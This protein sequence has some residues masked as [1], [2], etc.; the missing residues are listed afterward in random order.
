MKQL[1][2]TAAVAFLASF[3]SAQNFP[4]GKP[5]ST[6]YELTKYSKDTSA[7][8]VVLREFG[9]AYISNSD[10]NVVF[11]YH[12]RI[13]IFNS[14]G[15]K[16]GTIEIPLR[17]NDANT[18]ETIRDIKGVTFYPDEN[19]LLRSANLESSQIFKESKAGKYHDLVKFAMP[20][21]KDG[22]IIE[23]SYVIE[24]PFRHNFRNWDFQSEIPKIYTEYFAK[25][26]A[27]YNYN[28]ALRGAE[29]L[30]KNTAVLEKE[31]FNPGGG[32]KADCSVM[33]W[34]M[35][36]VPAFYEE[37]YMT[38]ASNFRSAM[39]FELS[40]YTDYYGGKHAVT[41][42]WKDVD[43]DL[44]KEDA[45][46]IQLKKKDFFE[47]KVAP[48]TAGLSSELEKAKAIYNFI[49]GWYKWDNYSGKYSHTGLKKAFENRTGNAGDINLSMVAA[50]NAGGL[51]AEPV[52]LSTRSN[53]IVNNLFPVL[54][55]FD[56]VICKVNIGENFYLLDGTDPLLPFGLLP[57]R[58]INDK[59]RVMSF[60]KPSYWI[61]LKASQKETRTITLDLEMDE[62]GKMKGR[63]NVF[64]A[65]YAAYGK[66]KEIKSFN[67]VDEFVESLDEKLPKIKILK[68]EVRNLDSLENILGESY[69]IEI[70]ATEKDHSYLNPFFMNRIAEN[71]FKLAE[72]TYPIDFGAPE[73][74][75]VNMQVRFP[76]KFEVVSKP[77]QTALSL[78]NSGGR[79][80][81][82]V[83]QE[84]NVIV[85]SYNMQ[86]N[87]PTYSA[88][89][90]PYLKELYNKIIQLQ[91]T[92]II[93][94]KKI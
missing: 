79:V 20:S 35:E 62:S 71:P 1:I 89:E 42:E 83:S 87:K 84:G 6:E 22:C 11:E 28:I 29:K 36:N 17:K 21:L 61:D 63:M 3:A 77:Q 23:Y 31:C 47:S 92:D 78:P 76:E 88:S 37:E 43:L 16:H 60:N 69:E 64:S 15:F 38:A 10:V 72:R 9:T 80:L 51:N 56:Y 66:R 34:A 41:K 44:K 57:L 32:F 49:R 7:N 26:P 40:D 86:L 59:G 52:I 4:F 91:Q 39:H 67:S 8:A 75:R 65:G 25:I 93:L 14:K 45:F 94:K 58:C 46:G 53:G 54:T 73:E 33:T 90:Y 24:S 27:I 5:T 68:S 70:N 50:M 18:F 12:V 19:N 74:V 81:A 2:L 85:L 82:N 48:L 55:E 30:S 13:K